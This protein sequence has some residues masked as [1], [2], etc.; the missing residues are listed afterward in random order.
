MRI[1]RRP[2][3][4]RPETWTET[5]CGRIFHRSHHGDGSTPIRRATTVTPYPTH[6]RVSPRSSGP[7]ALPSSHPARHQ[8]VQSCRHGE[9]TPVMDSVR[10]IPTTRIASIPSATTRGL[11]DR[12]SPSEFPIGSLRVPRPEFAWRASNGVIRANA[13][14]ASL[15]TCT[16][17]GMGRD[18]RV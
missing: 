14:I 4:S 8:R 11:E 16:T 3:P 7:R 2:H 18:A 5:P 12:G 6:F 10:G 15:A 9:S 1:F 13:R 17:H